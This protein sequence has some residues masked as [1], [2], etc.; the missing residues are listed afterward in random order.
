VAENGS[1]PEVSQAVLWDV[2]PS[3]VGRYMTLLGTDI[4]NRVEA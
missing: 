1:F 3:A 2:L 4:M